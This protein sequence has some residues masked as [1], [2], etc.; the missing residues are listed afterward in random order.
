MDYRWDSLGET[1]AGLDA[2]R[3]LADSIRVKASEFEREREAYIEAV[4][5]LLLQDLSKKGVGRR[6]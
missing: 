3:G 2:E 6:E 1:G 5:Q 4:K